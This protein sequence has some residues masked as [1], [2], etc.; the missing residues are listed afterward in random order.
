MMARRRFADHPAW[1]LLSAFGVLFLVAAV[2]LLW[3]GKVSELYGT[4]WAVLGALM[5]RPDKVVDLVRA[6]RSPGP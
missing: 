5:I 1:W 3:A 2:A 4:A 6:W